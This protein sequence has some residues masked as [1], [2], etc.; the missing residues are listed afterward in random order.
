MKKLFTFMIKSRLNLFANAITIIQ[1]NKVFFR[2]E[3]AQQIVLLC[4]MHFRII[5]FSFDFFVHLLT[6]EKLLTLF[7]EL[8]YGNTYIFVKSRAK[9]CCKVLFICIKVIIFFWFNIMMKIRFFP[10]VWLVLD[11]MRT[12]LLFYFPFSWTIWNNLEI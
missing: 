4:Y 2:K 11:K 1:D 6:V 7:E 8:A 3:Y 12:C 9:S 5:F 10:H